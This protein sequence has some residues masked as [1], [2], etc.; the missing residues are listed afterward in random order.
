MAS[1]WVSCTNRIFEDRNTPDFEYTTLP[2]I[3]SV[4][5]KLRTSGKLVLE[6]DIPDQRY[7]V[8]KIFSN[9]I[10]QGIIR[11]VNVINQIENI[12]R[13]QNVTVNFSDAYVNSA[14][15][16]IILA[17]MIKEVKD[18]FNCSIDHITLQLD[19]KKRTWGNGFNNYNYIYENFENK[20]AC[21]TFME[22][23]FNDVLDS[24]YYEES[25]VKHHR[26]LK[27]TS[28]RGCVELRPDH[29]IDGGWFTRTRYCDIEYM[30]DYSNIYVSKKDYGQADVIYYVIINR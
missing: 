6:G 23:I 12:L 2:N 14:L 8:T 25:N 10:C 13:D 21:N 26:W 22:N 17:Y 16:G 11:D 19:S 30:N 18:L 20:D 1:E 7:N 9:A 3:A 4:I 15:A 28:P 29:G 5:G 27:F 24:D